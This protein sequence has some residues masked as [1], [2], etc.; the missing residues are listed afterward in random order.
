MERLVDLDEMVLRC[1]TE[2]ASQHIVE[3]VS[4]YRAGAYR[5]CVVVTWVAVVYDLLDKARD[6]S[7]HGEAKAKTF[8]A[9]FTDIQDAH[10]RGDPD[11]LKRSLEFERVVLDRVRDEFE[12]LTPAEHLDL[13]RL[14]EDRNRCAHPTVNQPDEA[15][16]PTAELARLHLRNAVTH[17]LQQ[18]PAQGK[19]ALEALKRDLGSSYLPEREDEVLAFLKS[20]PLAKARDGL[21]KEVVGW[22]VAGF[23]DGH[24][25][26]PTSGGIFAA[27]AGVRR[28]H[29][30]VAEPEIGRRLRAEVAKLN[31]AQLSLSILFAQGVAGSWAVL[32]EA[33]RSR[34]RLYVEQADAAAV[35]PVLGCAEKIEDLTEVVRSR[36]AALDA[37][38]LAALADR[39]GGDAVAR[40]ALTL[41]AGSCS[42]AMSNHLIPTLILPLLG[43]FTEEL[44]DEFLRVAASNVEVQYAFA[45]NTAL[46]VLSD[47]KVISK[48]RLEA[49]LRKHGLKD[50]E[51][52]AN[53]A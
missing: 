7:L 21:V 34:I 3:A 47:K 23:F 18:P 2:Q 40:R 14:R 45:F 6:L 38:G 30:L 4:C 44:V 43:A 29:P 36:V 49:L 8:V 35:A 25:G 26:P 51:G 53:A 24:T 11:A 5:A 17:V 42:W 20:G 10:R 46:N 31:D 9:S 48:N 50:D 13:V 33:Q 12:M 1:R 15:Y 28:M 22:L 52:E 16:R 37:G 19:A 27:L 39:G 41:L 32:S